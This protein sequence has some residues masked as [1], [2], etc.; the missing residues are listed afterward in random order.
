MAISGKIPSR[1]ATV[2]LRISCALAARDYLRMPF[3]QPLTFQLP[4]NWTTLP[5]FGTVEARCSSSAI[6]AKA[7][8]DAL[9][10]S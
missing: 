2:P 10:P 4:G 3:F 7:A 6:N 8:N 5:L 9:L 1:W